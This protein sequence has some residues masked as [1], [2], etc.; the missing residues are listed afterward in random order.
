[1]S[2][3][4]ILI[5]VPVESTRER[6]WQHLLERT[7][8]TGV[9][10]NHRFDVPN[11]KVGTL[12][13]L[14]KESDALQS[15]DTYCE[16]VTRKIAGQLGNLLNNDNDRLQEIL[17]V[18]GK[19]CKGYLKTFKWDG[20]KFNVNTNLPDLS[21]D[22]VSKVSEIDREMKKKMQAYGKVKGQLMSIERN[23]AGNL[24]V[25]SLNDL[26]KP[27]D[28]ILD[29]E[30]LVTLMVVVPK[31]MYDTWKQSYERLTD[32]VVPR[33]TRLLHEDDEYGLFTVTL[34]RKVVDEFKHTA[35]EK[36]FFVRDYEYDSKSKEESDKQQ[37]EIKADVQKKYNSLVRW[38]TTMF[39]EAFIA[40]TH[41]K[42]LRLFVESVLRYGLPV[43]F[44]AVAIELKKSSDKK[45]RQILAQT[46]KHLDASGGDDPSDGPTV[47]IGGMPREYY[48]YVSLNA[49]LSTLKTGR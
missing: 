16:M 49:N 22:V 47:S 43:N 38:C 3:D 30:F 18:N 8:P 21:K 42:A 11:F 36:R 35:R 40:W 39:G 44:L 15:N 10:E 5:T 4:F 37:S 26:V 14:M 13:A 34:F 25:R 45:V 1:M 48:P 23:F 6:T 46:Y 32:C 31:Q 7:Q 29:S 12:D 2:D 33:S 41:T 19:T 9:C 27:E 17:Q 20:A 28:C 24:L